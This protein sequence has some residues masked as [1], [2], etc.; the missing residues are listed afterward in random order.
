MWGLKVSRKCHLDI[1]ITQEL[2][3]SGNLNNDKIYSQ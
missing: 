3:I 1:D 2:D